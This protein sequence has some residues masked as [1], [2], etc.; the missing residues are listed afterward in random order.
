[1]A[2]SLT[3]NKKGEALSFPFFCNFENMEKD[4]L[5]NTKISEYIELLKEGTDVL[6]IKEID[7]LLSSKISGVTGGFDLALFQMNKDLLLF[8]CKYLLA[9]FDFDSKKMEL[10]SKRIEDLRKVMESKKKKAV[11]TDPYTS[12]LQWILTLKKYYG[13]DIDTNNDLLYL[14][15]ATDQMM[16]FYKAQETQIENNKRK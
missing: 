11:K 5:K 10:Y 12:F 16:K 15:S 3:K 6:R 1:M 7:N 9:M 2:K 13:S 14:I 4:I 8:Q